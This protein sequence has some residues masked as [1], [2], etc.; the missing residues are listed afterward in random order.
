[1]VYQQLGLLPQLLVL[2]VKLSAWHL[3]YFERIG[4]GKSQ[5]MQP[6]SRVAD[7]EQGKP[8]RSSNQLIMWKHHASLQ[9][10]SNHETFWQICLFSMGS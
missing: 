3:R 9:Q 5:G 1:M 10:Q 7:L 6:Q 2:W 8:G 4:L